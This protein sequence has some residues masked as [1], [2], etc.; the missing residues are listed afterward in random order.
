[1]EKRR[2]SDSGKYPTWKSIG[3]AAIS[4]IILLIGYFVG[5]CINETKADA[6]ELRAKIDIT[7]DRVTKLETQYEYIAAT[8]GRIEKKLDILNGNRHGTR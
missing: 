7:C 6:K 3:A 4:I 5:G 1:M 2:L 8:T